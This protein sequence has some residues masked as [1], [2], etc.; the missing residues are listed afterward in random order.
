MIS[1]DACCVPA[2]DCENLYIHNIANRHF[3]RIFLASLPQF[4][5]A[6]LAVNHIVRSDRPTKHISIAQKCSTKK[7]NSGRSI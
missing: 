4:H 1:A 5:F 3:S 7:G 2:R 6:L